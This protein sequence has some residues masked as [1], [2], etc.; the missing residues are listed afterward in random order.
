MPPRTQKV[1]IG[2]NLLVMVP[3]AHQNPSELWHGVSSGTL[4]TRDYQEAG[5]L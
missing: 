3:N 1:F 5:T 4:C 2:C